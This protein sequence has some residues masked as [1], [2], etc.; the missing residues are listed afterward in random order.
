M[1]IH[2]I[3]NDRIKDFNLR[4]IHENLFEIT[5]IL[6]RDNFN[7]KIPSYQNEGSHYKDKIMSRPSHLHNGN[8]YTWKDGLYIEI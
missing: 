4:N 8:L 5:T 2:A 3:F 6:S 7:I 1:L